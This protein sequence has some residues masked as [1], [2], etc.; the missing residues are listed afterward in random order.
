MTL[1]IRKPRNKEEGKDIEA[2]SGTKKQIF[3]WFD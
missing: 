3:K 1:R 2:I